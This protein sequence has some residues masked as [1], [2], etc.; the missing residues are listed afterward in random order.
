MAILKQIVDY[1]NNTVKPKVKSMVADISGKAPTLHA[2]G[3]TTYGA[4]NSSNYGHVKLS[5]STS[6]N[7]DVSSGT[8]A[9]PLAVKAAYD[10]ANKKLDTNFDSNGYRSI[11]E[12]TTD[13]ID[14]VMTASRSAT[15][16][17]AASN[18]LYKSRVRADYVCDGTSDQMEIN[19]AISALPSGGGKVVLMEGTY[20]IS[21]SINVNKDNVTI[22]GMG[23][24]TVL[25][26]MFNDSA[27]NTQGVIS[28]TSNNPKKCTIGNLL[29]DSNKSQYN[30]DINAS[31][32]M[33]NASEIT[34]SDVNTI[35]VNRGIVLMSTNNCKI[36]NNEIH[37]ATEMAIF[38]YFSNNNLV[39][40]NYCID[41]ATGIKIENVSSY[42]MVADNYIIRGTG[43]A[44]DYASSQHT[45]D[46]AGG[47]Y[48]D[49]SDNYILGKNYLNNG[50]N[51]NTFD[52]N[53]YQ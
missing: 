5:D 44:A 23:N 40:G 15:Y 41:N 42:N 36:F 29:I 39:Q 34:V 37:D 9:T 6:S 27:W 2:V 13:L 31:I 7:S 45:I 49:V 17:I 38:V 20:N 52:N 12:I 18:S 4:G 11:D 1:H 3:N 51:T 47:T 30:S 28:V 8:A 14:L 46:L 21:G 48:N 10:L 16:V 35:N 24:G 32:K 53:R 33:V 25:K 19:N 50:G 26:R 43:Q 22:E